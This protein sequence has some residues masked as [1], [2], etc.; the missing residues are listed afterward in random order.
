[1]VRGAWTPGVR[2]MLV[3]AN[4]AGSLGKTSDAWLK[5]KLHVEH[6][7][8]ISSRSGILVGKIAFPCV[9][10]IPILH[11][12]SPSIPNPS[13]MTVSMLLLCFIFPI[14]ACT[15]DREYDPGMQPRLP[16][17]EPSQAVC[18][19]MLQLTY[20]HVERWSSAHTENGFS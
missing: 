4:K 7:V 11:V 1:M 13:H 9:N 12:S 16:W 5:R 19:D 2:E 20:C 8:V 14:L 3:V 6:F 18:N 15:Y 10:S 17:M